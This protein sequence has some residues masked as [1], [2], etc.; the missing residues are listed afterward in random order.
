[1]NVEQRQTAADLW[2]EPTDLR[3]WSAYIGSHETTSTIAIYYSLL[4]LNPKA[5]THLTIQQRIGRSQRANHL[6]Y[7]TQP[8]VT[9]HCSLV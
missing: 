4:S 1:M 3:H 5:D 9:G 6:A 2:T 7:T 8:N